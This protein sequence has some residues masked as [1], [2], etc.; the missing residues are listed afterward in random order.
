MISENILQFIPQRHPFVMVNALLH[1]DEKTATTNFIVTADNIFCEHG[2]FSEAGLLENIAQ[3]VAAGAG[4][5][6][7]LEGKQISGGYIAAVKNFE[8][9]CLP[10]IN[11][12]ITTE[13]TVIGKLFN[14]TVIH[15]KVY[16]KDKLIAECEIKIF[17]NQTINFK[18]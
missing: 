13:V 8:V 17:A 6:E 3:T 14:V 16:L 15:G 5:K 18:L 1:A 9:F 11:D 12:V 7:K 10:Q 2:K 4:Y